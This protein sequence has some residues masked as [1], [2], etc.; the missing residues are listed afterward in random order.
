MRGTI[1]G[2]LLLGAAACRPSGPP[3]AGAEGAGLEVVHQGC[4]RGEP[5]ACDRVELDRARRSCARGGEEGCDH[6]ELVRS[7]CLEHTEGPLCDDMRQRGELPREPPLLAAAA[8]CRRTEGPIGPHAV[9]CLAEHHVSLRDASG[10]WEQWVV[11]RW[12]RQDTRERAIRVIDLVDG[13]PLWLTTVEVE[14]PP[15]RCVPVV[16]RSGAG[17]RAE[18]ASRAR[19]HVDA[20]HVVGEHG[21]L[22]ATLGPRDLEAEDALGELPTVEAVCGHAEACVRAVAAARPRTVAVAREGQGEAEGVELPQWNGPRTLQRC[23]Q[24]WWAAASAHVERTLDH[25]LPAACGHLGDEEGYFPT[26]TP[27]YA[28]P[29]PD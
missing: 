7:I 23:H 21:L 16:V 20:L 17:G 12:G 27:P 4:E 26:L 11:A 29:A 28:W 5:G 2:G 1:V 9:V 14:A 8:G 6:L 22:R 18:P 10:Q 15:E 25:T 24:R 3:A 19:C 13:A